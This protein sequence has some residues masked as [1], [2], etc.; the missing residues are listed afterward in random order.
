[1]L[2]VLNGRLPNVFKFLAWVHLFLTGIGGLLAEHTPRTMSSLIELP[3]D[4]HNT[5]RPMRATLDISDTPFIRQTQQ[6]E[7]KMI[8]QISSGLVGVY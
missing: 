1:V 7:E 2:F 3:R 5:L 6:R 8:L 4:R